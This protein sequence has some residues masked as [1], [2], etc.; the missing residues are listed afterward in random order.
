MNNGLITN[1]CLRL[2][3]PLSQKGFTLIEM[4][5]VLVII[6][7]LAGFGAQM[8]PMLVK[9]SKLKDDR[10]LV[11]E[12][13]NAIIAYAVATGKLPYASGNANGLPTVGLL[14]GRLPWST[15]GIRSTNAFQMTLSYAVDWHLTPGGTYTVTKASLNS[16]IA[17]P[18]PKNQNLYTDFTD[19]T[20]SVW[21]AFVVISA[22]DNR[23]IDARNDK[24]GNGIN[25]YIDAGDGNVFE[26]T[27]T[28]ITSNYDDIVEAE[29]ITALAFQAP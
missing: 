15:L 13:K 9:Q 26:S 24:N 29:S 19:P 25:G 3:K 21:E 6:G 27:S 23:Q 14:N 20:G 5:F 17:A 1:S 22:G 2:H 12:A 11:K 16:L 28:T 8:I 7:I 18:P 4:A 10:E